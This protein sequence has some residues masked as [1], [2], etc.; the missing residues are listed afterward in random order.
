ME[1]CGGC[2]T[3]IAK[4]WRPDDVIGFYLVMLVRWS[5]FGGLFPFF[6]LARFWQRAGTSGIA[7][8][9]VHMSVPGIPL[10]SDPISTSAGTLAFAKDAKIWWCFLYVLRIVRQAQVHRH[11]QSQLVLIA[12]GETGSPGVEDESTSGLIAILF[13]ILF[14]FFFFPSHRQFLSSLYGIYLLCLPSP[15]YAF[16]CP[17]H[18][19]TVLS[20]I[21]W[22]R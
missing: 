10:N 18:K 14:L 17:Q 4:A 22:C 20:T 9:M 8:S 12:C 1:S 5:W 21:P 11:E 6:S 19:P 16:P 3:G 2:A 13:L 7:L 15:F